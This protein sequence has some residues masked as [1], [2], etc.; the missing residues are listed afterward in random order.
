MRTRTNK[1]PVY[2]NGNKRFNRQGEA[3]KD[4]ISRLKRELGPI[5]IISHTIMSFGQEVI[6]PEEDIE[7]YRELNIEVKEKIVLK[8]R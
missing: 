1:I 4:K 7:I 8:N 2:L 6:I 3:V 5:E